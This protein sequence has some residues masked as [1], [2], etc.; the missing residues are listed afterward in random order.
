M[1]QYAKQK[2]AGNEESKMFFNTKKVENNQPIRIKKYPII[3]IAGFGMGYSTLN[4][5][6]VKK[7]K[8]SSFD[9]D[10]MDVKGEITE[11]IGA[12]IV[13]E[14]SGEVCVNRYIEAKV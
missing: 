9:I 2:Q 7:G 4:A 8:I 5:V 6:I 3:G 10:G 11:L 1:N 12:Y 14:Y 13:C